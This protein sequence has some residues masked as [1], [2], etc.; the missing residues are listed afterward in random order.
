MKTHLLTAAAVMTFLSGGVEAKPITQEATKIFLTSILDTLAAYKARA[1][2]CGRNTE[3]AEE[4]G[5]SIAMKYGMDGA[6]AIRY[7]QTNARLEKG[8][9]PS[10]CN[11]DGFMTFQTSF[12]SSL[13]SFDHERSVR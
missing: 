3:D 10:E 1:E 5:Y 6:Q 13:G 2:I 4:L 8:R 7:V 12:Y 9:L 11:I